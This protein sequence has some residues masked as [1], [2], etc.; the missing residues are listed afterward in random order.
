MRL[1]PFT[2]RINRCGVFFYLDGPQYSTQILGTSGNVTMS[3]QNITVKEGDLLHL[4]CI[5]DCYP[6]CDYKWNDNDGYGS[7]LVVKAERKTKLCTCTAE[8]LF[9]KDNI[10]VEINVLCK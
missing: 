3:S 6:V 7:T 9:G 8:N 5:A 1:F 10:S 2:E 4:T